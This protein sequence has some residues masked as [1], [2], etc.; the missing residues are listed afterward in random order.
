L[1]SFLITST[2]N[3]HSFAAYPNPANAQLT[4]DLNKVDG[5]GPTKQ[6]AIYNFNV[7]KN[8]LTYCFFKRG[9]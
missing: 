3:R 8:A 2:N 6:I 7:G 4:I 5:K 9:K 1:C